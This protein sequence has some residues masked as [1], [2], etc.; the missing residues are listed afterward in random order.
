MFIKWLT[1]LLLVKEIRSKNGELHFRR[2]RFFACPW[3]RIYLHKICLPDYDEHMHDHP[4]NFVSLILKGGY[5]EKFA[6]DSNYSLTLC[7]LRR[8]GN[9]VKRTRYDIHKIEKLLSSSNW[10]L[11]FAWGKYENWG[12]RADDQWIDH[13][14]YRLRK[15]GQENRSGE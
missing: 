11:V 10:S 12:Y 5:L 15:N 14:L 6:T 3:F 4:W 13:K 8:P 9:I 2:W 7:E 1:D